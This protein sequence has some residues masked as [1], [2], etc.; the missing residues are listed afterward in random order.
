MPLN[1]VAQLWA[2]QYIG[3]LEDLFRIDE[4][5]RESIRKQVIQLSISHSV[6]T[7]FTAFVV[8]DDKEIV[9]TS[10]QMRE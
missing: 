6:L 10:G 7:R 5:S 4:R 9:N 2:K 3:E 8:V 1:A